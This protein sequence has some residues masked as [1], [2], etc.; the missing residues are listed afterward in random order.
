MNRSERILENNKKYV[1]GD[2]V[3]VG[4]KVRIVLPRTLGH[5]AHD[6]VVDKVIDKKV[7]FREVLLQDY[8]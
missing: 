7:G 2:D 4:D 5:K 6:I 1:V 3:K 8:L